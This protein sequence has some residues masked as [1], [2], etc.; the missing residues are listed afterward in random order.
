[1][2]LAR[3]HDDIDRTLFASGL[4]TV[5]AFRAPLE[6]P[7]FEDSGPIDLPIFVFPRT[8][9]QLQH[10]GAAPFT[11]DTCMVTYYNEGQRYRRQRIDARGD[12]CDWFSVR[13]DVLREVVATRDPAVEERP[14]R[15]F[16]MTHGPSDPHAYAL[17]RQVVRHVQDSPEPDRLAIEEAVLR[18]LDRVFALA[19]DAA[20]S[21]GRGE[22]RRRR[23]RRRASSI[24]D[25]ARAHLLEHFHAATSLDV[26]AR[27]ANSSVFHLCRA[28]RGQMGTS[29]HRYRLQLRLRR[30][31]ELTAEAESDLTA[32]ALELGFSSHSHFTAVFRNA[33][34]TTPSEFRRHATARRIRELTRRLPRVA[35]V[36]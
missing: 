23:R 30:A 22:P 10:E 11:T 36:A 2:E 17:Q 26:I 6:H 7:R 12:L 16:A 19:H 9:V 14:E 24:V 5:G 32:V 21:A 28:F 33:Y 15:P 20:G 35:R 31:L 3:S 18:V 27:A 4:V 8:S 13:A 29:I 1:M 34:G 25:A